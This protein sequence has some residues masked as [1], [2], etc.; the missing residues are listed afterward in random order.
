MSRARI[1]VWGAYGALVVAGCSGKLPEDICSWIADANNCLERFAADVGVGTAPLCGTSFADGVCRVDPTLGAPCAS[2]PTKSTNGYFQK[3]D[4]LDICF[5]NA[6]GQV[7]FDPPLNA[8]AFPLT[9]V[10][11]KMLDALAQPCGNGSADASQSF[12]ITIAPPKPAAGKSPIIAGTFTMQANPDTSHTF[13]VTCPGGTESHHFN[14]LVLEK[15]PSELR[16]EPTAVLESSPGAPESDTSQAIIGYVRLRI[17]YPP[18]N[19]TGKNAPMRVVEYFNCSIPAPPPPCKDGVQNGDETD[20]DCGGSCAS[21]KGLK[22]ADGLKCL[23]NGDC[24]SGTCALVAGLNQC[25][26]AM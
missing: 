17:E 24:Q 18:A 3:R 6:G 13:D 15:C 16:I 2:D 4:P 7:I 1:L 25:A 20:V 26:K 9:S 19:P 11:F 21:K 5:R 10:K 22:C 8:K 23:V 14:D 12:S